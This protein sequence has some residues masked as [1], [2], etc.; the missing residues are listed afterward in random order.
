VAATARKAGSK[1][2]VKVA[3]ARAQ[4]LKPRLSRMQIDV[5]T[6][7]EGLTIERNGEPVLQPAWGAA[8]PVDP[9]RYEITA[10]APGKQ[11]WKKVVQVEPTATTVTVTVPEL[12]PA[13]P[14][15]VPDVPATEP[16]ADDTESAAALQ[17]GLGIAVGVVGLAGIG[18]G[19]A[20]TAISGSKLDESKTHCAPDDPTACYDEQGVTLRDDAQ[21]AQKIYIA[22]YALGGALVITGVVLLVTM[23]SSDGS[24]EPEASPSAVLVPAF[25]PDQVGLTLLGQW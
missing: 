16:A 7:T 17:L 2:R 23:P 21:A 11:P 1:D 6:P 4:A 22:G 9:I 14:S 8:V 19:A 15:A 18:V 20:F 12:K 5:P 13:T 25:G 3:E 24:I 10:H